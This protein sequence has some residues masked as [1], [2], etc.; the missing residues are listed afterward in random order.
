MY[1]YELF[2]DAAKKT[3]AIAQEE[4]ERS[5]TSYLSTEHLLLALVRLRDSIAGEALARI[6]V[7]EEDVRA[8]VAAILGNYE[9]AAI[10]QV[11]ATSRVKR[12][13]ELSCD[14]ARRAQFRTVATDHLLLGLLAER[15]S[16]AA[17]ILVD[18]GATEEMI[19]GVAIQMREA[20]MSE[21]ASVQRLPESSIRSDTRLSTP[22]VSRVIA[23][24]NAEAK[25]DV[26]DAVTDLHVLRFV[27]RSRDPRIGA[28][29]R[30][31]GVDAEALIAALQPPEGIV[32]LRR[33][34][35]TAVEQELAAA[36]LEDFAAADFARSRADELRN[37]LAEAEAAWTRPEPEP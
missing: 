18:A 4:A 19:R 15:E 25:A 21:P 24:A 5:N 29:L 22:W 34:L 33:A 27:L 2:T 31:L 8:R 11:V 23:G 26:D 6:G 37:E 35:S 28:A 7:V 12:V 32:E 3:L 1:P 14:V 36:G 20:G 17:H 9:R 30:R 13:V 16:I 10:Q